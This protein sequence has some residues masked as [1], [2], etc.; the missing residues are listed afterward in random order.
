[1]VVD[2][3]KDWEFNRKIK[4]KKLT[5]VCHIFPQWKSEKT[6]VRLSIF[7]VMIRVKKSILILFFWSDKLNLTVDSKVGR[8]TNITIDF[9]IINWYWFRIHLK[10]ILLLV[11]ET[12]IT[13]YFFIFFYLEVLKVLKQYHFCRSNRIQIG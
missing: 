8:K 13:F 10:S 3:V 9:L 12:D 11:F 1:M 5:H 6:D 2:R 4:T 7:R